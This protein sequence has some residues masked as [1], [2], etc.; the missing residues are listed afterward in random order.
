MLTQKGEIYDAVK[1][2]A[3][4]LG[5]A[6]FGCAHTGPVSD[7]SRT[8][9]ISAMEE[10]HFA[11]MKYLHNNLEKRFNPQH[12]VEGADSVLV[13]L[14]PFSLPDNLVPPKGISQ[15]ALGQ[16]YHMVIKEKLY[17]IMEMLH[18]CVEGF[19]GRAFTDSAPVLEREWGVKAGLGFIGKNNFLISRNCGIKNFIGTIICNAGLPSTWEMEPQKAKSAAGSCGNCTKC[20]QACPSG[21]LCREFSIDARKCISYH[22]IE[23]RSLAEDIERGI[24]PEFGV[25]YYGCDSCMDACPWNSR[26]LP[27]WNEFHSNCSMLQ[28][29]TNEWWAT[30]TPAEF[31]ENFKDSAMLR[32]GLTN[33]RTAL[34]WGRNSLKNGRIQTHDN[35]LGK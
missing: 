19:C 34:E 20:L 23:N 22:T 33:I 11:G 25:Q 21:A 18:S 6:D 3:K 31:K 14:A 2:L 9:Y 7:I 1:A 35:S 30:L 26:N 15:Y 12:L 24:V 27:G 5:F 13:F 16:D 32:G 28:S 4:E 8:S 10:G 17:R 29:A